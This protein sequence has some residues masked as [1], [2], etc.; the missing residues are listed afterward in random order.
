MIETELLQELSAQVWL[1]TLNLDVIASV[2][3]AAVVS[4][5]LLCAAVNID[6][7]WDGQIQVMCSRAVAAAAASQLFGTDVDQLVEADLYD[8]IGE[9]ANV[10]GGAIKPLLPGECQLH[11]P[12]VGPIDTWPLDDDTAFLTLGD[13]SIAIYVQPTIDS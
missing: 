11:P 7:G 13:E 3:S 4:H 6:G 10:T 8:A 9:V 12:V 1:T 5:E 2:R